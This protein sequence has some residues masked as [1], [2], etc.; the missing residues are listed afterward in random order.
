MPS[1]AERDLAKYQK[2]IRFPPDLERQFLHDYSR[3]NVSA[4]LEFFTLGTVLY[5]AFGILD[6]W[7]LEIS[8]PLAWRLRLLGAVF[9]AAG[10]VGTQTDIF[11]RNI[12]LYG[13][14]WSFFP[15]LTIV[16]M[17]YLAQPQEPGYSLYAYGL[18]LILVA[19]YTT[20]AVNLVYSSLFG[21]LLTALY[22]LVTIFHQ[23]VLDAYQSR[24]MF[25]IAIFFQAGMNLLGITIGL[26]LGRAYRRDFLQRQVIEVQRSMEG[27][28]RDRAERLLHNILPGPVAER[29]QRG[30]KVADHFGEASILFADIVDF[31]PF[32]ASLKPDELVDTLNNIFSY[33]DELA[34]RYGLEKIRTIGDCYMVAAGVPQPFPGHAQAL[35]QLGLDMTEF[36]DHHQFA[37]Q[38][39]GLR[40]GVNS[41]P[42]VGG[43]IGRRKIFY[44]LWGDSVN[45][46][47]RM[48][49]HGRSGVVQ[50]TRTTYE[51]V[52]DKFDCNAQGEIIVKGKGPMPV[53]HVV[54]PKQR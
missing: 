52:K 29:L 35:V 13:P 31:T 19:I 1:Q 41:G 34:D 36:F 3:R 11:S 10:M 39:L 40:V 12:R 53:W 18:M 42:V 45:T 38:K 15:G 16:A 26:Y 5:L 47:S 37:G 7:A 43:V 20:G 2:S 24:L 28:L 21:W 8:Y 49:S 30:E 25:F 50:I 6:Y 27:L 48:E 22:A 32:T 46:A 33:F 23:N 54:G 14:A 44:D 4:Y 17:I 9:L 51:L